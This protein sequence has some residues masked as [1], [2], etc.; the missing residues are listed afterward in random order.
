MAKRK[1]RL[2][3]P[4]RRGRP[5]K[6]P[7]NL[8]PSSG[9]LYVMNTFTFIPIPDTYK[10]QIAALYRTE[11]LPK[12]EPNKEYEDIFYKSL[13]QKEIVTTRKWMAFVNGGG[14]K[15]L[16]TPS[17]KAIALKTL[18][19]PPEAVSVLDSLEQ[20]EIQRR[21][22]RYYVDMI[23]KNGRCRTDWMCYDPDI[24][25]TITAK[26]GLINTPCET[27]NIIELPEPE[28]T[29]EKERKYVFGRGGRQ[30]I[31]EKT[32]VNYKAVEEL[33]LSMMKCKTPK[34]IATDFGLTETA[35]YSAIRKNEFVIESNL[36]K[37]IRFHTDNI[38]R[39]IS[40]GDTTW[41]YYVR[42]QALCEKALIKSVYKSDPS[43]VAKY[44]IVPT[45][46]SLVF[47]YSKYDGSVL[48]V[49]QAFGVPAPLVE[50]W[51]DVYEI[52]VPA[53]I[54]KVF[55]KE[56]RHGGVVDEDVYAKLGI[57]RNYNP[58]HGDRDIMKRG[59]ML[60]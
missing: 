46:L 60:R 52:G 28:I 27:D 34:M 53:P 7:L 26:Y 25:N 29:T 59:D 20:F 2:S 49:S 58:L 3:E 13:A 1:F 9:K 36:D 19:L 57:D 14:G 22:E 51:L 50:K 38:I 41:E 18:G 42:R 33:R 21:Y 12:P 30:R 23:V 56:E 15:L 48:K 54:K 24:V 4:E 8:E 47:E 6:K 44:N 43:F 10:A 35:I 11:K 17:N 16:T 5:K 45:K 32:S 40:N 55:K 31:G 37:S 39:L